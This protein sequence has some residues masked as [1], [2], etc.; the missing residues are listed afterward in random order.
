M[1]DVDLAVSESAPIHLID[2]YQAPARSYDELCAR[3]QQPR[4]HWEYIIRSLEALGVEELARREQEVHRLLELVAMVV[5]HA[6]LRVVV[7]GHAAYFLE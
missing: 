2:E 5:V 1:S 6:G 7:A 3:P 4:P